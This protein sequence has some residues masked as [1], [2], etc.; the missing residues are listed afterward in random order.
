[1][2]V[3]VT[4]VIPEAG[5]KMLEAAGCMVNQYTG[6]TELSQ[7]Q[8]IDACKR[9]DAL[10]VAGPNRIDRNFLQS[11]RHLKVIAVYAA[12]FDNVDIAAAKE[13]GIPVGNTPDVLSNA[14]ADIAFLLMQAVARKA[15]HMHKSIAKGKWGFYEPT[16]NLGIELNNKTL[17][18]FG[19]GRIGFELA[20]KCRNAFNM[21]IIY[22][23]RHNNIASEKQL[24]AINVSFEEL[25]KNSDVLS[26]HSTLTP[27]TTG[28]FDLKAF[29]KMKPSS[30]F[31]NTGR[32]KLHNEKDLEHAL[33]EGY[34]W[35]A[36]LDVS[37]P[38]PMAADNALLDMPNVAVLPHIGSATEEARNG[39]AVMAA[40]NVLAGLHGNDLPY[41]LPPESPVV[42][43]G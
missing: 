37:N 25:L 2:L 38:E 7:K 17:G 41:P 9:S 39:M 5:I 19:L 15:F 8:L 34:I 22:H 4:R 18:I 11:C 3:F 27:D 14:T 10:I 23:N 36:G 35:G 33:R 26:L 40:Q 12:G 29:G 32:G 20:K 28:I 6:R 1:M 16:A 42:N 24:G 30:I 21:N 31:I 13:F 43:A